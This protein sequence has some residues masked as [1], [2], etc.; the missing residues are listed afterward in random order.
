MAMGRACHPREPK[1]LAEKMIKN[2]IQCLEG[3]S[4]VQLQ[5]GEGGDGRPWKADRNIQAP[6]SKETV[7]QVTSQVWS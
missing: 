6:D 3:F 4:V 1:S 2:R 5:S 7:T